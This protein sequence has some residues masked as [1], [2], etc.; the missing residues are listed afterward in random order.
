MA[1][2]Q[3]TAVLLKSL[4]QK[5]EETW[6]GIFMEKVANTLNKLH[7]KSQSKV[8]KLYKELYTRDLDN[9]IINGSTE[10]DEFYEHYEDV[11]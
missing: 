4:L 2:A 10:G 9:D 11:Y 6:N 3:N 5:E 1:E 7:S 8:K